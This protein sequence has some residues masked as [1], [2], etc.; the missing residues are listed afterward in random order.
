MK[1]GFIFWIGSTFVMLETEYMPGEKKIK[2]KKYCMCPSQRDL[3]HLS[4]K[5][6]LVGSKGVREYKMKTKSTLLNPC[7]PCFVA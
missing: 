5:T 1:T 4:Y 7:S 2:I 3:T 6:K